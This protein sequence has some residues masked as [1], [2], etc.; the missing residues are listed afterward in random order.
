M[1]P[2][3]INYSILAV[4]SRGIKITN[5]FKNGTERKHRN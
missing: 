1:I 3:Y 5:G 4:V 2:E